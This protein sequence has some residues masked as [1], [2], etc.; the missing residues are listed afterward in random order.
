MRQNDEELKR[1]KQEAVA[2][3]RAEAERKKKEHLEQCREVQ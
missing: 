3:R 2:K 1:A